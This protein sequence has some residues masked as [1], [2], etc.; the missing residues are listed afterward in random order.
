MQ[1]TFMSSAAG[2]MLRKLSDVALHGKNRELTRRCEQ[3]RTIYLFI[4]Q[5]CPPI[6]ELVSSLAAADRAR[7]A[8]NDVDHNS[9]LCSM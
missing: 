5:T 6:H 8:G 2:C 7:A 9:L 1:R 4:L 3:T